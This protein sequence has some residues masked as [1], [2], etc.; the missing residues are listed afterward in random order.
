MKCRRLEPLTLEQKIQNF[1]FFDFFV[2]FFDCIESERQSQR[3]RLRVCVL[4]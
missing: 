3:E 1:E 2:C 4:H